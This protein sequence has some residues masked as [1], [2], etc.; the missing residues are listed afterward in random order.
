M[1]LFGIFLYNLTFY[2]KASLILMLGAAVHLF[3]ILY[4]IPIMLNS[5]LPEEVVSKITALFE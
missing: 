1:F 4:N 5:Y 2:N 3:S